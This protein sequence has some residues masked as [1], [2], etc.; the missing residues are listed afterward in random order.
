MT[1]ETGACVPRLPD[2]CNV[3]PRIVTQQ[4]DAQCGVPL[5]VNLVSVPAT[6]VWS[7]VPGDGPSGLTLDAMGHLSWVPP[8]GVASAELVT[9]SVM[10]NAV[11]TTGRI[12]VV[13]TCGVDAGEPTDGGESSDGGDGP[14]FDTT[15]CTG[16]SSGPGALAL[17]AALLL[18]RRRH[19][20]R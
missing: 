8:A 9:V 14:R 7:F 10:I 17:L 19:H 3:P 11:V 16:C 2:V 6:G 4:L 1:C 13:V 12:E 15:A 5:E 18:Y 20:S